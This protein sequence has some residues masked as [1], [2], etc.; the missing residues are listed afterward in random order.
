MFGLPIRCFKDFSLMIAFTCICGLLLMGSSPVNAG[1]QYNAVDRIGAMM[2]SGADLV[3]IPLDRIPAKRISAMTLHE[4]GD[5]RILFI[6]SRDLGVFQFDLKRF[7]VCG[8][9]DATQTGIL[10]A[11]AVFSLCIDAKLGTL[12]LGTSTGVAEVNLTG[13]PA[14]RRMTLI[15]GGPFGGMVH[16]IGKFAGS[17]TV[18]AATDSGLFRIDETGKAEPVQHTK[19]AEAGRVFAIETNEALEMRFCTDGGVFRTRDGQHFELEM[20]AARDGGGSPAV[21]SML[22]DDETDL[23]VNGTLQGIRWR[24]GA[25]WSRDSTDNGLPANWITCL[26]RDQFPPAV[27]LPESEKDSLQGIWVGTR[28]NGLARRNSLRQGW[29]VYDERSQRLT[30]NHVTSILG[31][32]EGVFVG[33]DGGGMNFY[34]QRRLATLKGPF[35][36]ITGKFHAIARHGESVYAAGEDGIFL[37]E[38]TGATLLL[39]NH[40]VEELVVDEEGILW[41]IDRNRGLFGWREGEEFRPGGWEDL[42]TKNVSGLFVEPSRGVW[43]GL[44]GHDKMKISERLCRINNQNE[45]ERLQK[46]EGMPEADWDGSEASTSP[47]MTQFHCNEFA[48]AGLD[49]LRDGLAEFR[50]GHW[51]SHLD[52]CPGVLSFCRPAGPRVFIGTRDGLLL[53]NRETDEFTFWRQ[54]PLTEISFVKMNDMVADPN[55]PEALFMICDIPQ[56][57]QR[58]NNLPILDNNTGERFFSYLFYF[59][60]EKLDYIPLTQHGQKLLLTRDAIWLA[61]D[62]QLLVFL[63]KESGKSV[64]Q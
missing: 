5:E 18:W 61:T 28:Q 24:K 21:M 12:Y 37:C 64:D 45:I 43:F 55:L 54:E 16:A 36:V 48:Y 25:A 17:S 62:E 59:S 49:G 58:R 19:L 42:P 20:D 44:S 15:R 57:N 22:E 23:L 33:T 32:E 51:L 13:A 50:D 41:F 40:P 53:H 34:R 6:A 3:H 10:P 8:R 27:Q 2:R 14:L 47:L 7:E 38:G 1:M 4:D 9:I 31:L 46:P 56:E 11:D 52:R 26:G 30:N 35:A 39:G 63:M 29:E 60:Q